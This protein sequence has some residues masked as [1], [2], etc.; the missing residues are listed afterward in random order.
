MKKHDKILTLAKSK[1][2]IIETLISQTLIDIDISHK[3]FVTI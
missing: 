3:E 1:L 2:N